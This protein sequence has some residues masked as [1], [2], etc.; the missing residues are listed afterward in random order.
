MLRQILVGLAAGVAFLILDGI[1]SAN[2]LAQQLYAAYQPIARPG[3]DVIAGSVI[4]LAYGVAL[5]WLFV[6]LRASLPGHT[7]VAKAASFGL[8]V[9][10]LRVCMRVCGEWVMTVVPARVHAYTLGA[11]LVQILIVAGIIAWLLPRRAA[12]TA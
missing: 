9:W 7:R 11:G 2:P 5:A 1:F 8:I 3:V 4:D 10:F 6:T 12:R